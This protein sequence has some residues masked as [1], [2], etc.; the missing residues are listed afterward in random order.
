M[1]NQ[2]GKQNKMRL[3]L[4]K[5]NSN[6]FLSAGSDKLIKLWNIEK[7]ECIGTLAGHSDSVYCLIKL[8]SYQILS[9]SLDRTM[10]LWN[11]N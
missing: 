11:I 5:I 9:A 6:V 3:N 2:Y 8:N 4:L 7:G 10:R 1:S